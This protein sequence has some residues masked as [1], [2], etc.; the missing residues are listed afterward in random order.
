MSAAF[1][2]G[3]ILLAEPWS[4]LR[5]ASNWSSFPMSEIPGLRGPYWTSGIGG[6][7]GRRGELEG[8]TPDRE[9]VTAVMRWAGSSTDA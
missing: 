2:P 3:L 8:D 4:T 7:E 9:G 6:G 5:E 1:V